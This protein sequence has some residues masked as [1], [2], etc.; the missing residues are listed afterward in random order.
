MNPRHQT[1]NRTFVPIL[2]L[3]LSLV[4]VARAC[5]F[6]P[7]TTFPGSYFNHGANAVWLGVEWLDQPH[8]DDEITRLAND[9]ARRQIRYVF[10]Y[11]SYW[12]SNDQ[13]NSTYS[14]ASE[15]VRALKSAQ[16]EIK[17]EAWIGL[18]LKH[19]GS[20]NGN[21]DLTDSASRQKIVAFSRELIAQ[22]RFDGIH[23]DAEP[24]P[25]GDSG[26][27][28]LLDEL[29]AALGP[30]SI[31]SISTVRYWLLPLNVPEPLPSLSGWSGRYYREVARRVNQIAVLTYDT[32]L[33]S[34]WLYREWTRFQVIDISRALD[35]ARALDGSRVE[36]FF[37]VP[38]SEE[39]TSTH[40][41]SAENIASGLQGVVDGLNDADARASSVSGIAI[42]PYW[43]TD[44]AKWAT[45]ESL[46]LGR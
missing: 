23:L 13:F 21:V 45:Y 44:S 42:Y 7:A 39:K 38:T 30:A 1:F 8:G 17:V 32:G 36:L 19:A 37:G 31:L 40:T 3:L 25:D 29:R 26:V 20:T 27:L 18:P 14:H 24:I 41:P 46:W 34:A 11:T 12:K 28:A 5:V 10:A 4:A 2:L 33:T 16:P 15:F 35:N 22:N 43:E 6:R 9:L